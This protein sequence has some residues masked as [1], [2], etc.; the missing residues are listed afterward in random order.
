MKNTAMIRIKFIGPLLILTLI[1]GI[2]S[3][4][5]ITGGIEDSGD[6]FENVC[7]IGISVFNGSEYEPQTICSGILIDSRVVLTAG[8]CIEFIESLEFL[9]P[10]NVRVEVM[11]GYDQR[12]AL[13]GD[14]TEIKEHFIHPDYYLWRPRSNNYDVGALTFEEEFEN[15]APALLPD[16]GLLDDLKAEKVLGVKSK[17][18]VV[19][20]GCTVDWPP[21][22]INYFDS[23]IRRYAESSFR[24]LLPA[25]LRL[26]IHQATGDA[27][28]C[29]GDSGG[30][31]FWTDPSTNEDILVGIT[32]WGD[33]NHFVTSFNYRVDIPETLDFIDDVIDSVYDEN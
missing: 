2:S 3:A 19:G 20:Y 29:P 14:G 28:S 26:S 10:E 12:L 25:W 11:F 7:M 27:G 9:Y 22:V 30:P 16:Q 21:P 4:Y 5:A 33:V 31:V 17:F 32:S 1:L 15:I 6:I 24:A 23:F 8:Y 18:T 13:P